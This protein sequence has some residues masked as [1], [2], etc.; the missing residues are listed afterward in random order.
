MCGL[1]NAWKNQKRKKGPS[2]KKYIRHN[3][4][5]GIQTRPK[6]GANGRQSWWEWEVKDEWGQAVAKK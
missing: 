1:A 4:E 2:K 3:G 6:R 5:A